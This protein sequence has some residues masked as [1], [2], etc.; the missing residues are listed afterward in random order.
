MPVP[1]NPSSRA[2]R[3]RLEPFGPRSAAEAWWSPNIDYFFFLRLEPNELFQSCENQE[4]RFK[5]IDGKEFLQSLDRMLLFGRPIF[6]DGPTGRKK[7][8]YPLDIRITRPRG[9][10]SEWR[11]AALLKTLKKLD[12]M[13]L[14]WLLIAR[15]LESEGICQAEEFLPGEILERLLETA[16]KTRMQVSPTDLEQ[17][18]LVGIWLQYFRKL[19]A[20]AKKARNAHQGI[21]ALVKMGYVRSAVES[22]LGR[23]SEIQ[24][25]ASWLA[26]RDDDA[27][28]HEKKRRQERTLVN[29]CTRI[30]V[31]K[32][33]FDDKFFKRA[34]KALNRHPPEIDE[35]DPSEYNNFLRSI[36]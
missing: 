18:R 16:S 13:D 21:D 10:E 19:L 12:E 5:S 11:Y 22:T 8:G 17:A 23:K 34:I 26:L 6:S 24:A 15:W 33:K 30:N 32:N 31:A 35:I 1:R 29:A 9:A 28:G 25:T 36:S 2:Q 14:R 20:D 27:L 4:Q 7:S 3:R